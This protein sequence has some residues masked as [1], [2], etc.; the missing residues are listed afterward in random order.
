MQLEFKKRILFTY[1][2]IIT[3]LIG[4][5]TAHSVSPTLF[6]IYAKDAGLEY[7]HLKIDVASDNLKKAITA[8]K[9]LG[10][11]G[12]NVTLPH[13][14]AVIKYLDFVDKEAAE[15]GAVN[16]VT[17]KNGKLYGYNTDFYGSLASIKDHIS[18]LSSKRV[19]ILGTG[20]AARV[21]IFGFLKNKAMVSV[22]HRNP[23]STRTRSVMKDFGKR[24]EFVNYQKPRLVK[25]LSESDI[26]CNAT[27]CGM[28]IMVP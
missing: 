3:A 18:N 17:N 1:S 24:I 14:M 28:S 9:T 27:S 6:S 8:I 22:V 16:T 23:K 2:M 21:L 7:S 10:L 12:L 26:I 11:N 5:P 15:I 20:G 4:Y 19:L 13:K 25:I